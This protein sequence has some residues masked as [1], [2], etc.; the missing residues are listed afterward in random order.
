M[1]KVGGYKTYY[2][3]GMNGVFY[4]RY[5]IDSIVAVDTGTSKVKRAKNNSIHMCLNGD[6]I[7]IFGCHLSSSRKDIWGGYQNRKKEADANYKA[8]IR[9]KRPIIVMGDLND[10]SCTPP[11]KRIEEAGLKD[12]WW[13]GGCGYGATYHDGWLRLRVDHILYDDEGLELVGV[14]VIDNDLSDHNALIARFKIKHKNG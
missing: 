6:T 14:K 13:E 9:E 5:D 7:T 11:V 12:A 8:Y 3:S 10:L 1:T 2:R 4:S